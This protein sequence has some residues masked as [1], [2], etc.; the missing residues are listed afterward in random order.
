MF[1]TSTVIN[2]ITVTG[3]DLLVSLCVT[4]PNDDAATPKA[5]IVFSHGDDTRRIPLTVSACYRHGE[6][7]SFVF[8]GEILLDSV[9]LNCVADE[10]T[11]KFDFY[12]GDNC[13]E[14]I[15][16]KIDKYALESEAL[17]NTDE[18]YVLT[19]RSDGL[20]C[21]DAILVPELEHHGGAP[22]YFV[23]FDFENGLLVFKK[24]RSAGDYNTDSVLKK[25]L[26]IPMG[27]IRLALAICLLPYFII[28]GVL[29][30]LDLQK[31]RQTNL[32]SSSLRNIYLQIKE[33][34][35]DFLKLTLK[36]KD[37]VKFAAG[38]LYSFCAIRYN[39]LCKKDVIQN[40]V[41]FVSG[42][43]DN[44]TG[45][46][47][48]VYDEL[49]DNKDIDFQF[50][51]FSDSNGHFKY[52]Y[53]KRFYE[54]Y[55]TSK[56][57]IIDDYF[58]LTNTVKKRSET[59]LWQLWHACGAFKTFGYSRLGKKGGPL[60]TD[61]NH[62]MYDYTIVSSAEIAKHYAEGFGISDKCVLPTG[63]PRTD[64][65]LDKE[66]AEKI[67]AAFYS[68]HPQLKNKKIILFAPTFRGN[69]QKTAYYPM[70]TFDPNGFY[71][72]VGDDYAVILKLHPF[73]KERFEIDERYKDYIIDLSDDD[74]LN[75]LLFVTNILITDYSSA[76]FEA[77]LLDIPMIFYAFDLYDYISKRDFYY[78]FENFVPG[79]IV[80]SENELVTAVKHRDFDYGKVG[81]FKTKF[82]DNLDGNSSKRVADEI[83]K[84]VRGE[85]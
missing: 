9:F 21:S 85:I 39:R 16:F 13:V 78:D 79:K 60:Q 57:V 18:K 28:D 40:R 3:N 1:N 70:E 52:K 29:S 67:K 47:K 64:V 7:C 33:N 65:F 23:G 5:K 55:A 81:A 49:K 50:L 72:S 11:A 76:I 68:K 42:R 17:K 12:Y 48:F 51:L 45:N 77:S 37:I 35:A 53:I 8:N 83:L 43:R 73:C 59:Q 63:I 41:T 44:L 26:N 56:V 24:N 2:N 38:I 4:C 46:L 30:G 19:E 27:I 14:N 31:K 10:F 66:Y 71:E 15:L 54:L 6:E 84:A 74:E 75:D 80:F 34:I 61:I 69:G 22:L 32:Y 62:R 82:F 58:R 25:I 20:T 36:R